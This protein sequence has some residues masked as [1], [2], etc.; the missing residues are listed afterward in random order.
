MGLFSMCEWITAL[1][2]VDPLLIK[3]FNKLASL[4]LLDL[5]TADHEI[6]IDLFTVTRRAD[7]KSFHFCFPERSLKKKV[8]NCSP[9]SFMSDISGQRCQCGDGCSEA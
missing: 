9:D 4:S 6:I 7:L 1:A 2:V 3:D 5:S 8:S